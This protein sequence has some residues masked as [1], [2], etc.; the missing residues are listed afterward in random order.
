MTATTLAVP[1]RIQRGRTK[2]WRLAD[3]TTNP[4]GAVI[5]SGSSRFANACT[6]AVMREM[7]DVD[8]HAAAA[9]NFRMWLAGDRTNAPTDE[10]DR[11][12][13]RILVSVPELRGKDVACTC[14]PDQACHADELLRLAGMPPA[15][16]DAWAARVRARVDRGRVSWGDAPIYSD[17]EKAAAT[18]GHA[19]FV[20]QQLL[21]A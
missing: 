21:G 10:A 9:A 15:E 2:G 12:R 7:R 6:I 18:H 3:A 20:M 1:A 5:V 14:R 16:Y 19:G 8:P 17:E 4:N 13:E 11:R